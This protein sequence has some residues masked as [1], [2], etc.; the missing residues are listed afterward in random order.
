MIKM[1]IIKTIKYLSWVAAGVMV[2]AVGFATCTDPEPLDPQKQ[3]DDPTSKTDPTLSV[4][5]TSLAAAIAAGTY[6]FEVTS[7]SAWT[8]AVNATWCTVS[9]SSGKENGTVTVS[10]TANPETT[11]RTA[12][13]TV[14]RGKLSKQVSVAQA[15]DANPALAVNPASIEVAAYASTYSVEVTSMATWT[16]LVNSAAASWCSINPDWGSIGNKT[17]TVSVAEN[18]NTTPRTG[19]ITLS[20]GALKK[21]LIVNQVAPALEVSPASIEAPV[22]GGAY[23]IAVTSTVEWTVASSDAWCTVSPASGKDNGTVS[24]TIDANP[25]YRRT[26]TVTFTSST[27]SKQVYV[28]QAARTLEVSIYTVNAPLAGGAYPITVTA[29]AG[30]TVSSTATW[31][32]VS[33]TSGTGN[34]TVIV[35]VAENSSVQLRAATVTFT[36]GTFTQ[37]ITVNQAINS[38]FTVDAANIGTPTADGV[39]GTITNTGGS[40]YGV[41]S[42]G[43]MWWMVQNADKPVYGCSYNTIDRGEYGFLYSWDCAS[44]AC[45]PGWNLPTDADFTALSSWLTSNGKWSDWNSGSSLA[46]LGDGGSYYGNQGSDGNWWSSS[47]IYRLWFVSSGNASGVFVTGRSNVSLSVRCRKSQ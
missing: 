40:N 30:W 5:K 41:R 20:S 17:V 8:A 6:T 16:S 23:S 14:T 22:E 12:T 11:P 21:Q 27:L 29:N 44:T 19:T 7:D 37:W 33:P 25:S 45:P 28:A 13:V 10:V 42:M 4:D 39:L 31:C 2:A 46:G 32:T 3:P 36:S 15:A 38:T 34:G 47:S 1:I 26:A 43:G 35:N 24:V 9:P 18:P